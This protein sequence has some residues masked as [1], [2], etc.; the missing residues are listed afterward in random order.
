MG[1]KQIAIVA[2]VA[3]GVDLLVIG[4]KIA[5]KAVAS[6]VRKSDESEASAGNKKT[7]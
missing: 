7:K 4:T 5:A 1:L 3:L 6:R 2:G